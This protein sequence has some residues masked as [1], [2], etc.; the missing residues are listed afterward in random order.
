MKNKQEA[1]ADRQLD[2]PA[3]ANRDEHINFLKVEEESAKNFAIDKDSVTERREEWEK[4]LE[5]GRES[6]QKAANL[7]DEE[8]PQSNKDDDDTL[9]QQ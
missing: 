5:E 3:E 4:G 2:V 1:P 7:N 6:W 9:G 8:R